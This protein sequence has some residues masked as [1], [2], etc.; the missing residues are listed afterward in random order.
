[1]PELF[2][3]HAAQ[4]NIV[5]CTIKSGYNI[6]NG[7]LGKVIPI[8]TAQVILNIQANISRIHRNGLLAQS[9]LIHFAT[10]ANIFV[11][12]ALQLAILLRLQ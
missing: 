5:H 12:G 3:V 4:Q 9:S 7:G 8:H 10:P 2:L 6:K 1:M 11:T